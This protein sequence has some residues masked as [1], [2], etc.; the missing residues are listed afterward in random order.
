[1]NRTEWRILILLVISVFV[2]Y[3]DRG[4]LSIAAPLLRPEMGLDPQQ[5][6]FLLGGFF[7]TYALMQLF[8]IA[9][10][11]ADRFDVGI[12]LA[13]GYLAWSAATAA[14]GLIQGFTALFIMRL[15]LGAG[16]SLA[17][18]CYS[19]I[20]ARY[21]PEQSRGTA[22]ALIDAG[23]KIGPGLG[24]LLGGYFIASYGW[25]PLFVILGLGAL[26]WLIPWMAWRPRADSLTAE[27]LLAK[28]SGPVPTVLDILSKRSAWGT[29]FGL[30]CIN[31]YWY[32]LVTWLPLYL[33]DE[34]KFSVEK[35]AQIGA[36]SF[37]AIA[38]ATI[39]AGFLSD[40]LIREGRSVTLV[41]KGFAVFGLLASTIILPVASIEDHTT[42]IALL[43][44]A[45][46]GFGVLTSNHWAITQTL[47]GPRAAGRW[48]SLQNGVG[49]LAGIAAPWITGVIVKST[50]SFQI[51][52]A[53]SAAVALLG[54]IIYAF[55][56]GRVEQVAF[57]AGKPAAALSGD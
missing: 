38:A 15:I 2:N 16:E 40:R 53:T 4:N 1:M 9:G 5:M 26:V 33:V 48:T 19:L 20:L 28:N 30:F 41:R 7:W 52:F 11:L 46:M 8:G 55:V 14:T 42:A 51:A 24:T 3:I 6:G 34:R 17:Y 43:I 44:A 31:Y 27:G 39:A 57:A 12:V 35:M 18:P 45:C 10:W 23:S 37:F 29:F 22:N 21:F 36:L 25:R 32:F 47:A 13:A 49:N 50:G 56:V 54:A